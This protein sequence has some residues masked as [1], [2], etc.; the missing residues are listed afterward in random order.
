MPHESRAL[1]SRE[2]AQRIL[3]AAGVPKDLRVTSVELQMRPDTV[4][5]LLIQCVVSDAMAGALET[6]LR[7]YALVQMGGA[8][9]RDCESIF[10]QVRCDLDRLG[11]GLPPKGSLPS[12]RQRFLAAASRWCAR[13]PGLWRSIAPSPEPQSA[14]PLSDRGA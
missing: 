10:A 7:R 11:R 3:A 6:D 13:W 14:K 2:L 1:S 9:E 4:A 12:W 5:T 8:G